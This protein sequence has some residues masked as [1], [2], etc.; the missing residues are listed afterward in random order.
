MNLMI[1]GD[2]LFLH[3]PSMWFLLSRPAMSN[4]TVK[5]SRE[6]MLLCKIKERR[7]IATATKAFILP[8]STLFGQPP[9][10]LYRHFYLY[11]IFKTLVI[12]SCGFRKSRKFT[13]FFS[14]MCVNSE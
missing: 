13:Q 1:I 11:I 14:W 5:L 8:A 10:M 12:G 6:P 9:Q 2:L 7:R 4:M 3:Y